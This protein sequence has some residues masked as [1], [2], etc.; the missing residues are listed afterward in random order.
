MRENPKAR[1]RPRLFVLGYTRELPARFRPPLPEIPRERKRNISDSGAISHNRGH[2][3]P[4]I[5]GKT[6]P[7]ETTAPSA[8]FTQSP[9]Q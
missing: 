1:A 8:S 4:I 5:A 7:T 3:A 6:S 9:A 2:T